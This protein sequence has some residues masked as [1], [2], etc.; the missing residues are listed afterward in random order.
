MDFDGNGKTAMGCFW[1]NENLSKTEKEL[2]KMY[3]HKKVIF[4][5]V[6]DGY[7]EIFYLDSDDIKNIKDYIYDKIK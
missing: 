2:H 3:E 6:F 7:S 5:D 4:D 1:I